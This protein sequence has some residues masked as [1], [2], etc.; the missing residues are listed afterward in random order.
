MAFECNDCLGLKEAFDR[1]LKLN[2]KDS[3]E[4]DVGNGLKIAMDFIG[5]KN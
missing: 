4:E 2:V 3:V 1:Y 5:M